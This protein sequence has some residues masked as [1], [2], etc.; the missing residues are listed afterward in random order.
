MPTI[1]FPQGY[2]LSMGR[3]IKILILGSVGA[4]SLL[5]NGQTQLCAG[6][7]GAH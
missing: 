6:D 2:S 1:C 4:N 5:K 7:F 3:K